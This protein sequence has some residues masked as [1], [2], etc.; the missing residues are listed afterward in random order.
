MSIS[1]P[2]SAASALAQIA[3]E[4]GIK[5]VGWVMKN[6]HIGKRKSA[7]EW[8][9]TQNEDDSFMVINMSGQLEKLVE[10]AKEGEVQ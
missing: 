6:E 8:L 9:L 3:I 4:I 2:A 5:I 10:K 1:I 7:I